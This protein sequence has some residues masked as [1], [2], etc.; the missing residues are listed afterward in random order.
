ML[1]ITGSNLG[2]RAEYVSVFI[3]VSECIL[4]QEDYKPGNLHPVN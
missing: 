3:G 4:M 2:V 1:T